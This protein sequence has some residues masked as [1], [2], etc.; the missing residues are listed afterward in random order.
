MA[1]KRM[2]PR[3]ILNK[4]RNSAKLDETNFTS[5]NVIRLKPGKI[6]M[7]LVT[8]DVDFLFRARTQHVIPTVPN[9]DDSKEKWLVCDCQ[10][11]KCPICKAADA[12]KASGVTVDEV[13]ETYNP[14]YKY[15]NLRSV[16]TQNEH[17]LICAKILEDRADDG[18]YLPKDSELGSYHLVQF[19]KMALNSLM[20]SYED[21]LDDL[22]EDA[23]SEPSLFAIFSGDDENEKVSS[24][25][26]TCRIT[27]QPYS[28][29]FSFSKSAELTFSEVDKTTLKSLHEAITPTEEHINKC[30]DRIKKI[31]NYFVKNTNIDVDAEDDVLDDNDLDLN[32]DDIL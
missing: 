26:V 14:K 3:D 11:N 1:T 24:L 2:S 31:E 25:I 19:N 10:G 5:T 18:T 8:D 17:Y 28:Y 21:F 27:S 29:S 13:N 16:F 20:S 6:K 9:E 22:D 32:I 12:F 7:Q 30:V 15:K 23:E 4:V